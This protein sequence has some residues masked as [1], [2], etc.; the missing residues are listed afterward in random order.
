MPDEM[1]DSYCI[2][3]LYAN[4]DNRRVVHIPDR[5]DCVEVGVESDD[6][7]AIRSGMVQNRHVSGG[8][9]ADLARVLTVLTSR[10]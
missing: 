8:R 5:E 3:T 1:C 4:A 7:R 10:T 2:Q 6:H 9:H